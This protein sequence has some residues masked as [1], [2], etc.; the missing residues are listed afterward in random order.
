MFFKTTYRNL[1]RNKVHSLINVIGLGISI[2]CCTV[3][4]VIV[5]H[6]LSFDESLPHADRIYRI[7]SDYRYPDHTENEGHTAF[8][9]AKALRNDFPQLESVTQVYTMNRAIV[10]IPAAEGDKKV[11][12]ENE[13]TFA[14]PWFLRTFDFPILAGSKNRL[15]THP[16]EVILT[17]ELAE[18]YYGKA[19]EGRYNEL[20]GRTLTIN[21]RDYRISAVMEDIPRNSN[22]PFRLLLPFE[23]FARDNER[24]ANSME[25]M[26]SESYTFVMLPEN[27]QPIQLEK[28]LVAFKGK[29]LEAETAKRRTFHLQAL[30][31]VHSD[32]EYYGT[33]YATPK[34]LIVA[35]IS[36]GIIV[37][38]TS[39][40]NFINLATAQS[41]K[42]AKETGIRK[43]LGSSRW[44]LVLQFMTET[45]LLVTAASVAGL[46]LADIFLNA[47]NKYLLSVVDFGLHIT[48]AIFFFLAILIVVITFLA[49]Y[50]PALNLSGYK[51]VEALKQSLKSKK[52]GFSGGF[53]LRKALVIV[54]FTVSQ[55]LIIGTIVV[56]AQMNYFFTRD[57]GYQ[58][59]RIITVNIPENESQKLSLFINQLSTSPEIEDVTFCS[60]PPT[61]QANASGDVRRKSW[62][63]DQ[64]LST[65]RKFVD[66]HYL[67]TFNIKLLAGR[68]LRE[69]DRTMLSD[70]TNRYNILVNKLTVSSLGFKSPEEA[71]GQEIIVNKNELAT[72]VGVTADFYNVS[73]KDKITPC[74]MFYARNWVDIAAIKVRNEQRNATINLIR[75]NWQ[76]VFPDQFLKMKSMN[77]YMRNSPFYILENLMYQAF[78]IFSFLAV[79]IGCMGLYGLVAFLS[80]QRQKEIGIRKVLGSSVKGII[81]L[82][83]R[84]FLWLLLIAFAIAAPAAWYAMNSWLESFANRISLS[85]LFFVLAFLISAAIAALTIGSQAFRAAKAAPVTSLRS[86]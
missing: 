72:I 8:G 59:D 64:S 7:V 68:N 39:C 31:D 71:L 26:Y 24:V 60:G 22:V 13:M 30:K 33:S 2:A 84:E 80:A 11:F 66:P 42:R 73:L 47:F 79:L 85:P 14:D 81:L 45:L 36:M 54:Q 52:T 65:E 67:N 29:H 5:K 34:I 70:S 43:T 4:Y 61:S 78:K 15:L 62:S 6:E 46:V 18:K 25:E 23:A 77:E 63:E 16:D 21:K 76:K 55:L 56:A 27:Y 49:G 58:K 86:E 57:T 28:A 41:L 40:I 83:S 82:F 12:E 3:V 10:S 32:E 17:R 51:P 75:D 74:M 35:F 69:S 53:S 19:F 9:L 20:L 44:Q 37:L 38:L 1:I 50:Y 48:P